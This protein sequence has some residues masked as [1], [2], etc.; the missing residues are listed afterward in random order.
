MLVGWA[1]GLGVPSS[2]SSAAA[3]PPP[4]LGGAAVP[5]SIRVVLPSR[6][7]GR[8]AFFHPCAL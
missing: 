7:L 3:W 4:P 1:A 2:P 5:L 8:G 6:P